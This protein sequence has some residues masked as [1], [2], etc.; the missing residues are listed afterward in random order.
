MACKSFEVMDVNVRTNERVKLSSETIQSRGFAWELMFALINMI[1]LPCEQAMKVVVI[2]L[3]S[4]YEQ[5]ATEQASLEVKLQYLF[6]K[7]LII[8]RNKQELS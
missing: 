3:R 2:K 6:S 8:I 1:R 5:I 7:R 4:L